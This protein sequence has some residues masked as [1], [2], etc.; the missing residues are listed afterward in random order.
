MTV[1]SLRRSTRF[2]YL[3][4]YLPLY[5]STPRLS[6]HIYTPHSPLEPMMVVYI[7]LRLISPAS[8]I[9][10]T[11][12]LTPK[13]ARHRRNRLVR[14]RKR[15]RQGRQLRANLTVSSVRELG[16]STSSR[17]TNPSRHCPAGAACIGRLRRCPFI[18]RCFG[19][20]RRRCSRGD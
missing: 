13:P 16:S 20:D 12:R 9:D 7:A 11:E 6:C 17:R 5:L 8:S 4:T 18:P 19:D 2:V 1:L 10:C 15:D 14:Q 3:P